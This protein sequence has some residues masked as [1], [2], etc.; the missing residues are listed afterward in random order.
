MRP[1][2]NSL[3]LTLAFAAIMA[4]AVLPVTAH[5]SNTVEGTLEVFVADYFPS[6]H[7]GAA[8]HDHSRDQAGAAAPDGEHQPGYAEYHYRLQRDDGSEVILQGEDAFAG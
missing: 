4:M 8:A 7:E 5:T 2:T 1:N 3:G 6:E